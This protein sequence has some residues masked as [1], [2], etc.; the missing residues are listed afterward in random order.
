MSRESESLLM[1]SFIAVSL[2]TSL[3]LTLPEGHHHSPA[4]D[5]H[6]H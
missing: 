1:R 6:H 2:G 5:G 3:G 4:G